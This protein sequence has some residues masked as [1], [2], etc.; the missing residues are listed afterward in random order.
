[1]LDNEKAEIFGSFEGDS[2]IL[3]VELGVIIFS[4][5][6]PFGVNSILF[7]TGVSVTL[8]DSVAFV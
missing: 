3:M 7:T 5:S 1:M 8:F 2:T 4:G 6:V